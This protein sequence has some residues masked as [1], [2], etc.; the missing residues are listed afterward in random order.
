LKKKEDNLT[1]LDKHVEERPLFIIFKKEDDFNYEVG[2]CGNVAIETSSKSSTS[3]S[4]QTNVVVAAAKVFKKR[5]RPPKVVSFDSKDIV[6]AASKAKRG[7]LKSSTT[8]VL[9]LIC[10]KK[11]KCRRPFK[12]EMLCKA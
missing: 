11:H 9:S 2:N 4:N 5:S 6:T 7:R 3:T 8:S 1:F 10:T 12:A